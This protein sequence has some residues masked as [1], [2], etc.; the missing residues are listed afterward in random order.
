MNN[1]YTI[2]LL[3][4]ST[5]FT[6]SLTLSSQTFLGLQHSNMSGIHQVNLNP[7]NIADSRHRLY[8]NGLTMGVGFN[9]DYLKL[10]LPFP[11]RNLVTGKVPSQYK[12]SNGGLDIQDE[13]LSEN[14]NGKPKNLNFY[15]QFRTP[16]IM[17]KLS[18]GLSVGLQYKNTLSFQ[19]N[20]VAEPLARLG[21][22]G[23]DSS[24][25]SVAFSGPNNFQVGQT[26][27]DNSFTVNLNAFGE[28]GGTVA[29]TLINSKSMVLKIGATPK[30][31][32]GYATGYIKNR[33]IQIKAPG[34]DTLIFGQTDVEYGYTDPSYFNDLSGMSFDLLKS[35][36]Q[37]KGFGLDLGATFEYKPEGTK[38]VTN[39]KNNYLFRAGISLLDAGNIN[40]KQK[41][42]NRHIVNNTG[43]KVF[44]LGPEF[45]SA[46]SDG[47][48]RGIKY[49]DSIMRTIFVIDSSSQHIKSKMPTTVNL[50]FDYN[51]FKFIYVGANISQDFRG[52]KS[53][54]MRKPSYFMILPRIETK[55]FELCLPMGL[56]ND[57]RNGRMGFY[58][59]VG[60]V[61]IGS[62]NI[63]GQISS[64]NITG[65]DFYFG[66]STGIP[67]KKKG[68]K[69][70]A[71]AE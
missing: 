3:L 71:A 55:I 21:R 9:N 24:N 19:I 2:R 29:K 40:Y 69:S 32:L 42:K 26:F 13:W 12:N 35:K 15:T 36:V 47:E 41:V 43:D 70:D 16:G 68:D 48:E 11:F 60:P 67:S 4:L 27:G 37:G 1:N 53:V 62:D 14:L 38:K 61:F 22:Y 64:N 52:K 8:I 66:I 51:V 31:L 56:M 45:A 44:V 17:V 10:S 34:S 28:I 18:E 5:L 65:V 39:K 6:V 46:W 25:G 59:R 33:G 57:Y 50:Q 7:A 30:L 54:G 20:D 63:I 49:T 23:I 58:L